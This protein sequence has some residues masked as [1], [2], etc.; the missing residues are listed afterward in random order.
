MKK[1][2]VGMGTC[3]LSAGARDTYNRLSEILEEKPDLF[4]LAQQRRARPKQRQ[5]LTIGGVGGVPISA[6]RPGVGAGLEGLAKK[7]RQ[8]R[9]RRISDMYLP[10][11]F[12]RLGQIDVSGQQRRTIG[13]VHGAMPQR[14][15]TPEHG[16]L[17][18]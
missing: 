17:V 11:P 10:E 4:E 3:G 8:F 13:I 18:R 15:P 12:E 9:I 5:R 14:L 2:I 7:Q 16:W 6:F 1:V